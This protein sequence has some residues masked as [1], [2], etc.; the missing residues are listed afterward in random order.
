MKGL[1]I[2]F[3]FLSISVFADPTY[4]KVN[5]SMEVS[6]TKNIE[7]KET[8]NMDDLNTKKAIWEARRLSVQKELDKIEVLITEARKLGLKTEAELDN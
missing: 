1:V 2:V 7:I 5:N 3:M 6:E 4:T 8:Y